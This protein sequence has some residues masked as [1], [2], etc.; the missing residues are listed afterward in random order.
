MQDLSNI[1]TIKEI[2]S[3]HGFTFSKSL[4]QNFLINPTVC[5]GAWD[6]SA[7]SICSS[8]RRKASK[9]GREMKQVSASAMGWQSSTPTS[10]STRGSTRISGI[11][12]TPC[13]Q[14]ARK[15]ACPAL[16]TLW[17]VMLVTTI[18]F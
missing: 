12:H 13:R 14:Q 10:P 1:N 5:A 6:A 8:C 18:T 3:A 17:K 15:V 2:L 11:K 7:L 9:K 16:P 4:G